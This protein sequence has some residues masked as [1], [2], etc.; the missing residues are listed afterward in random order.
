MWAR[1]IEA[2]LGCWLAISPFIFRMDADDTLLWAVN[3]V[4]AATVIT[5]AL[6]SHWPPTRHARCVTAVVSIAIIAYGRIAAPSPGPPEL[7]N[8]ILVGLLLLMFSLVPNFASQ[9]PRGWRDV[10]QLKDVE[11]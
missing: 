3:L 4:A 10:S 8:L 2:M 11:A 7:R 5:C 6:L 1:V 9:P